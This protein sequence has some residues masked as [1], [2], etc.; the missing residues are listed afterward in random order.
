MDRQ[1]YH[2]LIR[3]ADPMPSASGVSQ[4]EFMGPFL[5]CLAIQSFLIE[6]S[7]KVQSLIYMDDIYLVGIPQKMMP[8]V[9]TVWSITLALLV[10]DST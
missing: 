6:I 8:E 5:F 3:R 7:S 4:G 2:S 10:S 1:H 9:I